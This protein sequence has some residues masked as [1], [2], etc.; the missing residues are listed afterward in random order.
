MA[1]RPRISASY[2]NGAINIESW[3]QQI[4]DLISANDIDLVRQACLLAQSVNEKYFYQGLFMADILVDLRLDGEALAAAIVYGIDISQQL[5]DKVAKLVKGTTQMSVLRSLQ[6]SN[7]AEQIDKVRHMILAMVD[8]VRIV[9][10]KLSE[11][12]YLLHNADKLDEE[13]QRLVAQEAMNIYAPLANRLGIG[14]LKWQLED[15]A[16]RYLQPAEYKR[17]SKALSERREDRERYVQQVLAEI[18]A[19]L[20]KD[21]IIGAQVSGRA[22]HIYSIY[23]KM[24]D[25]NLNFEELYDVIALRVLV[26][27]IEDCYAALSTVQA[28]WPQIAK[29]FDDYIMAPKLNGYASIH[30]GVIGPGQRHIE[31]QIR[32]YEMHKAAEFGVA[33]HWR[34]KEGKMKWLHQVMDWQKELRT[35]SLDDRVYVFTPNG[36]IK[37]LIKGSTPLD[38]AYAV[39]TEVGHHCRGSKVN[40]RIVPLTYSLCTG[41]RIEILTAKN[42]HP[43]R[44][45]LIPQMGYLRS[46]RARIKVRHWFRRQE[47]LEREPQHLNV[48]QAAHNQSVSN[49]KLPAAATSNVNMPALIIEGVDN[50]VTV[51]A[52]CCKP[53]PGDLIQGYVTVNRG[54]SVHKNNCSNILRAKKYKNER[55]V[56]INWV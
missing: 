2:I 41:D 23:R 17:L 43:S 47:I 22:K 31:I 52:R 56:N 8:D 34:Y 19:L 44:D 18:S 29:E 39:H 49:V 54:I 11:S 37:D 12:I 16:F 3:L 46:S 53:E 4:A 50:L 26:T 38:F 28:R 25:K 32:T 5:G 1:I 13:K 30:T 55:L 6:R 36:E 14:Q 51:V 35:P 9:I 42:G 48:K 21:G 27:S 10:I 40:G 33:A 15:L 7:L 20:E 45:W 24:T